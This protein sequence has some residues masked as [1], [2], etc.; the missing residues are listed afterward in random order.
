M[1]GQINQGTVENTLFAARRGGAKTSAGWWSKGRQMTCWHDVQPGDMLFAAD[2]NGTRKTTL[3]LK[4]D[5]KI[6]VA[7]DNDYTSRIVFL[8]T[9]APKGIHRK[10]ITD[11]G[12]LFILKRTNH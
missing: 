9:L 10:D 1:S 5:G 7:L 2:A 6:V 12:W 4:N 8:D 11:L 3:I